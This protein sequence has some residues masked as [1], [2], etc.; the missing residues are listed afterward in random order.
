MK[1]L[2]TQSC[3]RIDRGKSLSF[4]WQGKSYQGYAGDTLA[5][6]L[7]ANGVQLVGRSFKYGRPRGIMAAGA[8]EPNALTTLESGGYHVPNARATQVELYDNMQSIAGSGVPSLHKDMRAWMKPLHRF[9]TAGFYYKTF[10]WPQKLWPWYEENLRKF[11]GFS[12]SP[13]AIDAERYDH[14][15]HKVDVAVVGGGAAGMA[16]ALA[17]AETGVQVLLLDERQA[18]GGEI[19]SDCARDE[20]ARNWFDDAQQKLAQYD[21]VT[22]LTRTTGYALHDFNLLLAVEHRQDHLP[23]AARNTDA[24]RQRVHRIRANQVLLTTGSHERPLMFAHNDLPGVMLAGAVRRYLNEFAVLCGDNPVIA[25]NNDSIYEV[26]RDLLQAGIKATVIDCRCGYDA[27]D[28]EAAGVDVRQGF[29]PVSAE[30]KDKV[31]GVNIARSTLDNGEWVVSA[32]TET[33]ACDVLATSGGFSPLVH[34]DCHTGSKPVFSEQFQ[35]FM[36]ACDKP[37]RLTAGSINGHCEW[38]GSV[39]DGTHAGLMAAQAI[40]QAD[41]AENTQQQSQANH[42]EASDRPEPSS[43]N[44][45]PFWVPDRKREKA[46]IDMQN[47]VKVSDIE[48]AIEE[49]YQSIEHIKRYTAMGFGTDQGKTGNVNGIAVAAN[50]LKRPIS[51]VGTT[52]FRP[53]YTPV[54]LGALSGEDRGLLF[55]PQRFTPMHAS[56]VAKGADFEVV[57]QW[58]RPWYFPQKGED[59]HAAVQRESYVARTGLA[60]MDA[61]TLGKIDIQGPDAREFLNRVYTNAWLKLAPGKCR[62]GLMCD[63]NGM[64]ID[65]GVTACINDQ[66]FVMTTTTGGAASVYTHLETWLQTE[67]PDLNVYLTSVTDHW[68]TTAVVGP[69]ARRLMEKVCDDIDF[70]AD[71][72]KFMDWR[73]GTVLGVPARVMRISFSGELAYEINVQANYGRYIW[74]QVMDIGQEW[75]ITP[76]GTETMHVLRAEKGFIIVGQDTDGSVTPYD[77]N[78]GWAVK[79]NKDYPFIGQRAFSRSDTARED[80]KQLVGLL[81]QDDP[82]KVLPEGCQLVGESDS[83]AMIGHVTSSYMSPILGH[84]IAMAVVKDGF[85]RMGKTIYA[86]PLSGEVIPLTVGSSIFYDEAKEKTDGE[87]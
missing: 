22:V 77:A 42:S 78:M 28:L 68:S 26:A 23:L 86:K 44:V 56:H 80:R 16:A 82:K 46:F 48:L 59:M 17:A 30:G 29:M 66:H 5:S 13:K 8:E 10:K 61:S 34:L 39:A 58:M 64:I 31:T 12:E 71:N 67:W 47:D 40:N 54:S 41:Q 53:M 81:T 45:A 15:Y 35:A 76:Y 27:A 32:Q 9:M 69:K 6:A 21:N 38:Q 24:T 1:R 70:S 62:Y 87:V 7:L 25:G 79:T 74:D 83:N 52:T 65:D 60:M 11:A 20:N 57:G 14:V 85:K 3:E 4:Q 37:N 2:N 51:E 43:L 33:L 19:I 84:S 18:L 55:D 75:A 49:N 50:V 73:E 36:P 72:F 63:E